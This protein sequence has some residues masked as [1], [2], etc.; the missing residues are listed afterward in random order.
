MMEIGWQQFS[1][2]KKGNLAE[3]RN[4]SKRSENKRQTV[5]AGRIVRQGTG[6]SVCKCRARVNPLPPPHTS[7]AQKKKSSLFISINQT[8]HLILSYVQE[9]P[10]SGIG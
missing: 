4:S 1:G 10:V 8:G 7:A 2:K 5:R 6:S 3:M 9:V